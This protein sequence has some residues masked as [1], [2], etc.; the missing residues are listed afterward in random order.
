[1]NNT[2]LSTNKPQKITVMLADDHPLLRQALRH[3]L[4]EEDD[5]QII[6]EAGDGEEAI[7]IATELLPDV[8]IMDI[9][10]PKM[11]GIEATRQ[12]KE[13]C[14]RIAVLVLTVYDDNEHVLG[15][16]EAGAA[17][18]LVKTIFG[19][20]VA[21]A[22]RGIIAGE[23]VLSPTVLHQIT[24]NAL[25]REQKIDIGTGEKMAGRELEILRLAAHGMSN[26]AI[27]IQLNISL[28]TVK[29]YLQNIFSKLH[30]ASRTEAV[31]T[32]IRNN[33]LT[34]DDLK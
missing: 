21:H 31:I 10:M 14:P 15:I 25:L 26:K 20:T 19:D 16:L 32:S 18:Y 27:A 2:K 7:R 30:V 5:F 23:S 12:I 24:K 4:E 13:K 34:L 33:I 8:V 28:R 11:N 22:V 6:A 17:G 29:G 3:V 1:M 9:S